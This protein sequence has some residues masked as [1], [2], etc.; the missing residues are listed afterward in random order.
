MD[1]FSK[2]LLPAERNYPASELE[3][4]AVVRAADHFALHLLGPN[5]F[6]LVTDHHALKT[7]NK[8][9]GRL[10]R[11]F[12]KR[13]TLMWSTGKELRMAMRMAITPSMGR[14][15]THSR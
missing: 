9:N 13:T 10:M 11:W 3:C 8:L 6:T 2:K 7:S 4:L 5:H 1:Y 14:A 12:Y 15:T